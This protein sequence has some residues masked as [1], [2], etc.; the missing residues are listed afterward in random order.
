M[1]DNE[2]KTGKNDNIGKVGLVIALCSLVFMTL[3]YQ[4][5]QQHQ[6]LLT[7][8]HW[9]VHTLEVDDASNNFM[10]EVLEGVNAVRGYLLTGDESFLTNYRQIA[11]NLPV[12][13]A[14]LDALTQDN[15][16][17]QAYLKTLQS[18]LEQ[19]LQL[20]Q[21]M[22]DGYRG[23]LPAEQEKLIS[24]SQQVTQVIKDLVA[25]MRAEESRL[26]IVR[27]SQMQADVERALT[28]NIAVAFMLALIVSVLTWSL[29]KEGRHRRQLLQEMASLNSQLETQNAN[30]LAANVAVMEADRL[31]TEFLSAMSHELRTPLNSIIGFTGVLRMGIPGALNDEQKKQLNMVNDSS[32]HLLHLIN[33]LLDLSR[34]ESGRVELSEDRFDLSDV[35]AETLAVVSPLAAKK[36]LS[37]INRCVD[38]SMPVHSDQRKVYQIL[39]NLINNAVKFSARG[40]IEVDCEVLSTHWRICVKDEGIGIKAEYLDHLFQAFRQFDSST[41]RVYEGTGLGLHLSK[42]L[43]EM[44]GGEISVTSEFGKGSCFCFTL[45][46]MLTPTGDTV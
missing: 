36:N 1:L 32:Q 17:E 2:L 8:H 19:R 46:R 26:L 31:K 43:V 3:L 27:E 44:L 45:P 7:S 34:I 35:V 22:L 20:F 13:H 37:L 12:L 25:Q 14:R 38:R 15:P 6:K 39:L 4:L 16:T 30:L 11:L 21:S 5:F 9:V 42:K 18:L 40:T 28:W 23:L 41:R 33:D 24:D 29:F 10:L